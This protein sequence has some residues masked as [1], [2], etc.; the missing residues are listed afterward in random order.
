VPECRTILDFTA[1]TG[2]GN[3]SGARQNPKTFKAALKSMQETYYTG[4]LLPRCPSG[5]PINTV[6]ALKAQNNISLITLRSDA[7]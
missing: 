1:A 2:D 4:F 5:H 6:K 7:K 3:T